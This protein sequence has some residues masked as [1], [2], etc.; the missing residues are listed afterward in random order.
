MRVKLRI[1]DLGLN[2]EEQIIL[3]FNF[4]SRVFD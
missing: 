4:K 2:I 3:I 1:E